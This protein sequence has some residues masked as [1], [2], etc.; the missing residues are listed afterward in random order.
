MRIALLR[1]DR[2]ESIEDAVA[3]TPC[4]ARTSTPQIADIVLKQALTSADVY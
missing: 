4:R 1:R 3:I 2:S